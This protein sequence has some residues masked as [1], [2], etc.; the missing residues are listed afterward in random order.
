M[1]RSG[2]QMGSCLWEGH[3][4][5]V[6]FSWTLGS[7]GPSPDLQCSLSRSAFLGVDAC[8]LGGVAHLSSTRTTSNVLTST[9]SAQ[10]IT[11]VYVRLLGFSWYTFLMVGVGLFH[12]VFVTWEVIWTRLAVHEPPL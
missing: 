1:G 6:P 12:L 4:W 10:F 2:L 3:L 9:D 11:L 8:I 7:F 5:P